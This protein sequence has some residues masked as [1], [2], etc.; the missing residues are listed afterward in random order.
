M[1]IH[2][3]FAI[4]LLDEKE[5]QE[6]LDLLRELAEAGQPMDLEETGL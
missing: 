3:G 2:V 1:V 6:T 4:S 5:A